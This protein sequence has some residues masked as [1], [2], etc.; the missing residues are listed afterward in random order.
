MQHDGIPLED[1][2]FGH[3]CPSPFAGC[4]GQQ[5]QR[6]GQ[7]SQG[8]EPLH[9]SVVPVGVPPRYRFDPSG[10]TG[11]IRQRMPVIEVMMAL[12]Q[13]RKR[14]FFFNPP[15]MAAVGNLSNDLQTIVCLE[16]ERFSHLAA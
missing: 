12:I 5:Y 8:D 2:L 11:V 10:H 13:N 7:Q 4:D 6:L 3:R 9:R 1:R 14:R 16:F 15:S